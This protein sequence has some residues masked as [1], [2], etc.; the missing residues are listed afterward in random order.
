MLVAVSKSDAA[1]TALEAASWAFFM[2]FLTAF[3]AFLKLSSSVTLADL[4]TV[5][6]KDSNSVL[7]FSAARL[8]S[9]AASLMVLAAVGMISL[10]EFPSAS[11]QSFFF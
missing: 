10:T 5:L 3:L 7:M 6:M 11:P 9:V 8:T 2:V 1:A 4:V